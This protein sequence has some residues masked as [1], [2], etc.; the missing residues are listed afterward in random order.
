MTI[1]NG[2]CYCDRCDAKDDEQVMI[3]ISKNRLRALLLDV[4]ED[5]VPDGD[6]LAD[7]IRDTLQADRRMPKLSRYEFDLL[8]GSDARLIGSKADHIADDLIEKIF[9]EHGY[10]RLPDLG[11]AP[12]LDP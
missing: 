1:I 7:W 3:R 5:V 9:C 12:K 8:I 4:L 10:L 6:S 2:R 11:Y